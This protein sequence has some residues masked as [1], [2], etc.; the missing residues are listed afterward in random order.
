MDK[1]IEFKE[2]A[3][4]L[5]EIE[6]PTFALWYLLQNFKDICERQMKDSKY[7]K[8]NDLVITLAKLKANE[9]IKAADEMREILA[10]DLW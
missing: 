3:K 5:D 2:I 8:D 9:L 10:A 7:M 4:K 6:C 1:E